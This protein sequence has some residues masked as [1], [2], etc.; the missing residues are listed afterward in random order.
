MQVSPHSA[1]LAT[2]AEPRSRWETTAYW[3]W[4]LIALVIGIRIGLVEPDPR[5]NN[6]YLKVFASAGE[7]FAHSRDLYFRP[8]GSTTGFRYPPLAAALFVPFAACGA[9]LG[10]ILWRVLSF[11]ALLL[12]LRACFAADFPFRTSSRQRA[13]TLKCSTVSSCTDLA[14]SFASENG[15]VASM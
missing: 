8:D 15:W 4:G 2:P 10:S 13:C 12:G 3:V 11:A 7:A 14:G 6:V 1:T 5:R 9:R